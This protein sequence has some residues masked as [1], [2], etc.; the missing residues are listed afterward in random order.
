MG[1]A[2]PAPRTTGFSARTG[3]ARGPRV[4]AAR[5]RSAFRGGRR[6]TWRS[7]RGDRGRGSRGLWTGSARAA[8][9]SSGARRSPSL[10]AD[11]RR[12]APRG[13]AQAKRTAVRRRSRRAVRGNAR[14]G[15]STRHGRSGPCREWDR[16]IR[17]G[18]RRG[19]DAIRG[20]HRRRCCRVWPRRWAAPRIASCDGGRLDSIESAMGTTGGRRRRR[21]RWSARHR[22]GGA[23]LRNT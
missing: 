23:I 10:R 1:S 12:D 11:G 8:G 18:D 3:G 21:L 4:P 15:V 16:G 20:R 22:V 14:S 2:R 7:L 17:P 6:W 19:F 9:H 5:P 13:R